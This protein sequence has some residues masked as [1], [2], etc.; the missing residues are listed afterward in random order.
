[1]NILVYESDS[2][3]QLCPSVDYCSHEESKHEL[4]RNVG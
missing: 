3:I 1:M 2:L 4:E